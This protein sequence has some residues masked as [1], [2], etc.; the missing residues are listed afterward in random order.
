MQK[1]KILKIS[2]SI[3][4]FLVLIL[5]IS[6]NYAKTNYN[7]IYV[8]T[9]KI[10]L[11]NNGNFVTY[12]QKGF[13]KTLTYGVNNVFL[14]NKLKATNLPSKYSLQD[15]MKINIYKQEG[16]TCWIYSTN[17]IIET[18]LGKNTKNDIEYNKFSI[19]ATEADSA[20]IYNRQIN[21]GGNPALALSFYTGGY[22]P[23]TTVGNIIDTY[24]GDYISIASIIKGKNNNGDIE[25]NGGHYS[26]QQVDLIRNEIKEHIKEYGAVTSCMYSQGEEYFSDEENYFN[27]EAYYC[28]YD[29]NFEGINT[30]NPDHQITIIGW[31]DNYSKE[32]FNEKHRPQNDGAYIVLNSWGE[33]FSKDGIF[34]ISYEDTFV[35]SSVYGVYNVKEKQY[36]NL[37]QHDELGL[38]EIFGLKGT[39]IYGANVF[40]RTTST[41]EKLTEVSVA[42][43][44]DSAYEIYV[45][46]TGGE[47]DFNKF[48]KVA[49]TEVLDAGYHTIKL[50]NEVILTG[51]KFVIAVKYK[52]NYDGV[53]YYGVEYT[54]VEESK[55]EGQ[56]SFWE[57]AKINQGESYIYS[58]D[59][60]YWGDIY[61]EFCTNS[62]ASATTKQV[63]NLCIKGFTENVEFEVE[64]EEFYMKIK[65]YGVK[66]RYIL[67][68]PINTTKAKF[69]SN[70]ESNVEKI[71]IYLADSKVNEND[72]LKTGMKIVFAKDEKEYVYTIVITGDSNGDGKIDATDLITAV[73]QFKYDRSNGIKGRKVENE[74][75]LAIKYTDNEKYTA[76]DLINQLKVYK[77]NK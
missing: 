11:S 42:N 44:V 47:L 4:V 63:R 30:I 72:I 23:K 68:V 43:L 12:Y 76:Q 21:G 28:D 70:I 34:Y 17:S 75:L 71:E 45:N 38:R 29:Y 19:N 15:D 50:N 69:L 41:P 39:D 51:E 2:I 18:T 64:E 48:T 22:G 27:S 20:K 57:S 32:N 60:G 55:K 49:E 14:S 35:E 56:Q 3:L 52:N 26:K 37:Y 10:V 61:K 24:I 53:T 66:D 73:K 25:Y 9:D 40:T 67:H 8:N 62:N 7:D 5:N 77:E 54:G 58:K 74:A 13:D 59:V 16:E 6:V 46:R 31:D 36:D 33:N 65:G 1:N